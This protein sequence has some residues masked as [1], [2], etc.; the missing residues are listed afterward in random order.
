MYLNGL[1]TSLPRDIQER[2]VRSVPGLENAQFLRYGYAVEYDVIAARQVTHT[3][4]AATVP[5]LYL[6]GQVLGTSGYEEAAA[7]GFVAGVNAAASCDAGEGLR[8]GREQ[9]YIGVMI[10]DIV[11]RD[12]VEPYRMFTSRSEH[13]LVLGVDSARERLLGVGAA[14]GLVDEQ[15]FHVEQ[16]RWDARRRV[17]EALERATLN[18][19]RATR[20][21]VARL[22]GVT[23]ERQTTWAGLLRRNDVDGV[24]VGAHV[25]AL[26]NLPAADRAIVVG[27]VRYAGYLARS[28][29]DRD[30][31]R[32]LRNVRIPETLRFRDI[33]GLSRE[34]ADE[35][36]R[37]RPRDLAEAERLAGVTPAA[38]ALLAARLGPRTPGSG[39]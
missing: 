30:R 12:H 32:R 29:R 39:G 17:L 34:A 38:L 7:L 37:V 16:A 3:L 6:A 1:S 14:L 5:G 10:D 2:I 26:A 8:L 19:D 27:R 36:E 20:A 33:P 15:V 35:M 18:P 24:A 25:P 22:T 11:C 28:R 13:R 31:L 4:R 9:A 23:I 21:R